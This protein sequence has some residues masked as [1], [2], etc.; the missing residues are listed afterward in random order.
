MS[1]NTFVR[2]F[3]S[4]L[5]GIAFAITIYLGNQRERSS[6][7]ERDTQRYASYIS[8][9][10]LPFFIAAM[11]IISL[12]FAG[13]KA[14]AEMLLSLCFGIF[15]HISLYYLLLL[16]F[17]P[18]LRK[19]ISARA[20]ASLWL[21][22][23]YLYINQATYMEVPEPFLVFHAPTSMIWSIFTLW[24]IGFIVF[25]LWKII[26][27][28][29][30][31]HHIL[32]V[33]RPVIGLNILELWDREMADACYKNKHIQLLRSPAVNTPLSIGFFK[34]TMRVVLPAKDYT[35]EEL[36]LVFR[37][38]LIHIGRQD[39]STKFFMTFCTAMCWFNP[40]MWVAMQK[41]AEDL[42]LSCD[43]TVLLT[44]TDENRK[45]Y[46]ELILNTVGNQRGFTTCLAASASSLR[47]RLKHIVKPRRRLTGGIAVGLIFFLLCVS[48]GHVALAYETAAG[49][50]VIFEENTDDDTLQ[51]I[52]WG[53]KGH[54]GGKI[55]A[56]PE[57][58]TEY[59][60]T[61]TLSKMTGNY[62]LN[63]ASPHFWAIFESPR[64]EIAVYIHGKK[65]TLTYLSQE[66]AP[67][68]DYYVETNID[69]D[70]L[71]SLL[72][73]APQ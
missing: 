16:L 27:H 71:D 56:E 59:L 39:S 25:L 73:A 23:N 17:L 26:S 45:A 15:L 34:R 65:L 1:T 38:E 20:C 9:L 5:L 13:I 62:D 43:E 40:L 55:C 28:L 6:D 61:L 52:N 11:V 42:E 47:Y 49:S 31:R 41:S 2:I 8:A 53:E 67:Q 54:Y 70:Y 58:L 14:T 24:F 19:F 66:D 46:A 33:A 48:S 36:S 32:S 10:L 57:L 69:W 21:I 12:P 7:P 63:N 68:T 51:Y 35:L 29:M 64:G 18:V 44:Q 30:F 3:V 4:A 22:P 60:S 50:E 37:H 72:T